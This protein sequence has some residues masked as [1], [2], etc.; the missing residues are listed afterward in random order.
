TMHRK[1]YESVEA[2]QADLDAWLHHYNHERP[3]LGY[4]N[5]GRR[6]WGTVQR[7]V[8]QEG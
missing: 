2:L 7:F 8:R 6:P 5:Q 1:L 4:R 3:H